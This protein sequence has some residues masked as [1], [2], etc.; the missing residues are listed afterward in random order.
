MKRVCLIKNAVVLVLCIGILLSFT[1]C[2]EDT[3]IPKNA[4]K[5]QYNYYP[6]TDWGMTEQEVMEALRMKESDIIKRGN[7][8][9]SDSISF[10]EMEDKVFG[11]PAKLT[12]YFYHFTL[13]NQKKMSLSTIDIIFQDKYDKKEIQRFLENELLSQINAYQ[14]SSSQNQLSMRNNMYASQSRLEDLKGSKIYDQA[15][16]IIKEIYGSFNISQIGET[17][18][19]FD[20]IDETKFSQV[21][22]LEAGTG[23]SYS[24]RFDG[25]LAAI[26]NDLEKT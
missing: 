23:T 8:P 6:G 16:D 18:S 15:I 9:V 1:A 21:A 22:I 4:Q 20:K 24:I 25:V 26:V 17:S 19:L 10:F 14:G 7:S 12:F 11:Y 3:R 5:Y 2:V 13:E